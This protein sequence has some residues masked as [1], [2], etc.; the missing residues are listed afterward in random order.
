MRLRN[1]KEA[2]AEIKKCD[3]VYAEPMGFK[4][5]WN[6]VFGNDNDIE[7]EIGMGRGAFICARAL[8]NPDKNY[9]GIERYETIILKAV[10]KIDK[11]G[12]KNVRI[13]CGD[14]VLVKDFFAEDEIAKIYLNFSDPWPKKRHFK[15]RLTYSDFLYSYQKILKNNSYIDIK[16]DNLSFFEFSLDQ[17]RQTGFEIEK[18]SYDLHGTDYAERDFMTEYETKFKNL[19][20]KI[21]F[22][23]VINR[24]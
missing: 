13:I 22:V 21:N 19:G 12:I 6:E 3:F 24:K 9:I 1:V 14:A 2:K 10:K 18:F 7:L 8:A 15:N 5:E 20:Q 23:K 11:L 4:G 16:T 17:I